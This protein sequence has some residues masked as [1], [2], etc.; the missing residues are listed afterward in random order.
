MKLNLSGCSQ[1]A[2]SI[3]LQNILLVRSMD[4]FVK[5]DYVRTN[6]IYLKPFNKVMNSV[7]DLIL[8]IM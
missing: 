5:G 8:F 1:T 2:G 3:K 6:V 4:S 7:Q